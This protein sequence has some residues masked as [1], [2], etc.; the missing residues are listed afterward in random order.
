MRNKKFAFAVQG[1]GRG[2]LTQALALHEILLRHGHTVSCVIVGSS[3]NRQIP[4]FFLKNFTIPVIIVASPNFTIDQKSKSI[5]LGQTMIDNLRRINEYRNSIRIISSKLD[6]HQPDIVINFYEPLLAYYAMTHKFQFRIIALA[7][8]YIYLHPDFRFPGGKNLQA[9]AIT[10]YTRLTAFGS[11]LQ[12]AISMYDI[13]PAPNKK[14]EVCPPLLRKNIFTLEHIEEDFI[15]VYLLNSGY[16]QDIVKNHRK[17][18]SLKLICF[19]DSREVKEQHKGELRLNENL[20]FYSLNDQKFMD[21]LSRCKGLV[22]TAGFESVCEA[23]YLDKP[24]MMVP[25][26]D[27][28][29]QYCNARDASRIGAG[30]FAGEFDLSKMEDCLLFYDKK[31]NERYRDWVNGFESQFLKCIDNL[32]RETERQIVRESKISEPGPS[33][34]VRLEF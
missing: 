17:N 4:E 27:H 28:Y 8:Q 13:P 10:Q 9:T 25:V 15:L 6:E 19:T 24:V 26:K 20:V 30:I 18:P 2:H 31:K 1:E 5:R 3:S 32:F 12:L 23:M 7:H 21:F 34:H 14:L 29:E 22:C 16:A 11:H 33:T